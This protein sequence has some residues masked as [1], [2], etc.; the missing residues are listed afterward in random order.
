[1]LLYMQTQYP[2]LGPSKS[3]HKKLQPLVYKIWEKLQADKLSFSMFV[4][5]NMSKVSII[6]LLTTLVVK[7][8]QVWQIAEVCLG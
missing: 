7:E 5:S 1:M 4:P 6:L 3:V 8:S 2:E